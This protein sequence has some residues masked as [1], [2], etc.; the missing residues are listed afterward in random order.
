MHELPELEEGE[1]D[2]NSLNEKQALVY[3]AYTNWCTLGCQDQ[4]LMHIQGNNYFKNIISEAPSL[5]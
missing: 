2:P 1:I 4:M 3:R 5:P